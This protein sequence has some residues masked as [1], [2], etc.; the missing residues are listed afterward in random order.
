MGKF[1]IRA[2]YDPGAVILGT[3]D[4]PDKNAALTI[5]EGM[6]MLDDSE[7]VE[8]TATLRLKLL[9]APKA[10]TPFAYL[11]LLQSLYD[12]EINCALSSFWD[13][14]VHWQLGDYSNGY[15][16]DGNAETF[17]KAIDELARAAI[18]R[19]PDSAFA[20]QHAAAGFDGAG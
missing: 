19:Y 2:H 3:V 9:D 15:V 12:S 11:G 17:A 7:P 5:A 1:I 20:K 4:A 10:A 6:G 8:F 13:S 16:E 14:G 18:R